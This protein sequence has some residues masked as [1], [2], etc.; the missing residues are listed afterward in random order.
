MADTGE[1]AQRRPA[2]DVGIIV[3]QTSTGDC[4]PQVARA[5]DPLRAARSSCPSLCILPLVW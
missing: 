5:A 3:S 4:L 1:G 2:A